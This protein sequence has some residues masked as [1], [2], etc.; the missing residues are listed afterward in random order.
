MTTAVQPVRVEASPWRPM[1]AAMGKIGGASIMSGLLSALGTKIIAAVLG[2]GSVAL[3]QTLQQ[4]RDGAVTAATANGRTA[5]VQGA[6]ELEGA[7]RREYLRT[8]ALLFAGGT[9]LVALAMLAAPH[10][11]VLWSR[12]PALSEPLLPWLAATVALFSVFIFLTAILN[13]FREFGKLA[14]LQLASPAMAAIIAWPVAAEVRAGHPVA[15]VFLLAIPAA[16]AVLV[17]A[18]ALRS[19][20]EQLR[21]WFQ[22]PGRWWTSAAARHFLS[23]SGAMLTSGL[24]ATAVLLAVRGSIT[25]QESLAI[26]G[27]FDAAWNISMNHVTLILGSVQIYYLPAMAAAKS[28]GE[29]SRQMRSMLMVAVLATTPVIVALAVLKPLVVSLLY[30]HAFAASPGFLRWTLIG[31][32]LKVSSWV[33]ATPMLAT[34]DMGAFL[35]LDLLAQA[36][37]FGSATFLARLVKPAESAAIGFLVSYAVYLAF[38]YA[39]ARARN[40]FRLGGDARWAWLA[41]L[42]LV[43]GA[44]AS[45]WS[46]PSVHVATAAV[47]IVLATGFSAGLAVYMRRCVA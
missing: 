29:R 8:V 18:C 42:A 40:R 2:P 47:W 10:E 44:S 38:C 14:L 1:I 24:A 35:T 43:I 12:L 3:L 9:F 16:V 17:V 11:L 7:E 39:H 37:F 45:D 26:T 22:G 41:G 31:D 33:L 5:L 6:S 4:L 20:R 13:V 15:M 27:Q 28:A 23:I 21:E 32:Y 46:E 25:R 30:S 19:H 34:R 36:V